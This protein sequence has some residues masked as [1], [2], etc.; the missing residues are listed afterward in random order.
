MWDTV[1]LTTTDLAMAPSAA[2][3]EAGSDKIGKLCS[4]SPEALAHVVLRTTPE[5]YQS[6]IQFYQN[7]LGA[8]IVHTTPVLTFLRYDY[9]HHRIAIIQTPDTVPKPKGSS[10]AGLDHVAFTFPTLTALAQ[11][12]VYLKTLAKP[13][14]PLWTVNHGPTTSM[15]YR[16]PDGNKI[17]LQVDNFDVPDDADVFMK[18]PLYAQNPMGTDFDADKWADDILRKAGSNGEEGLSPEEV[19]E[20]KMRKEIGERAS[21]PEGF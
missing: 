15:Y 16:D 2:L 20:R 12:Y 6:M 1:P 8:H 18:G 5:T 10:Y 11:Q 17:E 9:E 3:P 7:L 13:L 4:T 21:L 19:K 14:R